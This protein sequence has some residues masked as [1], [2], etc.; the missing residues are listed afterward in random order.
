MNLSETELLELIAQGEGRNLEFKRGLPRDEKLA[1]TLCAFA[2]TRGGM[3][4]VG[5]N[6]NGS[7]H[8]CPR[9]AEVMADIRRVADE[10]LEPPVPIEVTSV[11]CETGTIVAAQVNVSLERPHHV[12]HGSREREIV[13][14]VGSSNRE[15]KGATLTAL[16]NHRSGTRPRDPLEAKILAWVAE[17][18]RLA[19]DPGGDATPALFGESFNI[20]QQRA[21]KAF[22]RLER[23][24]YLVAHGTGKRKYYGLP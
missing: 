7:L 22:V 13:V 8:L 1:R 19:R 18:G 21:R 9:P 14:R 3:L 5:V 6:D 15:A 24:G 17:R 11:S 23:D 2:N 12:V 10:F 16:H 4:M 20:G